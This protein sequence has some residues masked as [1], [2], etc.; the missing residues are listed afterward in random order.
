[1]HVC[2]IPDEGEN[3]RLNENSEKS[4]DLT[5]HKKDADTDTSSYDRVLNVLKKLDTLYGPTMQ[6]MHKP[7]VE[8]NYKFMGDIR[9][10]PI[11]EHED[12]EIRWE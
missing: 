7:V 3:L 10:I 8:G 4:S 9:V 5:Y 12:D 6:R 11:M 2:V 1:M